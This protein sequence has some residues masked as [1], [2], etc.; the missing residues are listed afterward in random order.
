MLVVTFRGSS[1]TVS[2]SAPAMVLSPSDVSVLCISVVCSEYV[3][4]VVMFRGSD[5]KV[6]ASAPEM[7]LSPS[8]L[9]VL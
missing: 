7:V 4:F 1:L 2:A 6:S 8:E 3:V 9:S 5:L